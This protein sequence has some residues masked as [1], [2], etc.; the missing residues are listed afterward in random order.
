VLHW[1]LYSAL[2]LV[3]IESLFQFWVRAVETPPKEVAR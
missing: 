3:L 2:V 1:F